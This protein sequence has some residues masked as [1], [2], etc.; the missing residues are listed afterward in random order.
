MRLPHKDENKHI[1]EDGADKR[2]WAHGGANVQL[3]Q[4]QDL[5]TLG[6]HSL[7]R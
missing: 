2:V 5:L 6:S 1:K 4:C 3:N 7:D